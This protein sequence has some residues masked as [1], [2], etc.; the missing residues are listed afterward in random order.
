MVW[1]ASCPQIEDPVTC[2]GHG[3]VGV[4]IRF[5]CRK[6]ILMRP[7]RKACF[8]F[9]VHTLMLSSLLSSSP[10]PGA[11]G[12]L[13]VTPTVLL[14]VASAQAP[15]MPASQPHAGGKPS[16][17]AASPQSLGEEKLPSRHAGPK[18]IWRPAPF[19]PHPPSSGPLPLA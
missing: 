14:Q 15:A 16:C 17:R 11:A 19:V 1:F 6:G 10:C 4:G 8:S 9:P 5:T 18:L 7:S 13:R 12:A 2:L 3:G